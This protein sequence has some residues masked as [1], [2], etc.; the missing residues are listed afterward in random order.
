MPC[1]LLAF[2]LKVQ[3]P[4]TKV[5]EIAFECLIDSNPFEPSKTVAARH[6]YCLNRETVFNGSVNCASRVDRVLLWQPSQ[7]AFHHKP[8]VKAFRNEPGIK[9]RVRRQ[10]DDES[11]SSVVANR[12]SHPL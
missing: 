11:L 6:K 9:A 1:L 10:K 2:P 12:E 5:D 3:H 7:K 8:G 4:H